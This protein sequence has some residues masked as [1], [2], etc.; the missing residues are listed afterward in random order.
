MPLNSFFKEIDE[1]KETARESL[2]QK[3]AAER[4]PTKEE[5]EEE[6]LY[7]STATA[8]NKSVLN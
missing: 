7:T 3:S 2:R 1:Y 8:E 6:N 4:T 5:P